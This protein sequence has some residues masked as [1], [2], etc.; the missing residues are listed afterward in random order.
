[1]IIAAIIFILCTQKHQKIYKNCNKPPLKTKGIPR[2]KMSFII[3]TDRT[4]SKQRARKFTTVWKSPNNSRPSRDLKLFQ[5]A[6]WKRSRKS[7]QF[8]PTIKNIKICLLKQRHR[9]QQEVTLSLRDYTNL[10]SPQASTIRGH[11]IILTQR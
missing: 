9:T 3:L 6:Q 10:G 8:H 7:H 4:L 1:M 11:K 2:F 5:T